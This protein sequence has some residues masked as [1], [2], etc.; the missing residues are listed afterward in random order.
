VSLEDK[1]VPYGPSA[2]IGLQ[3]AISQA[4]GDE[5]LTPVTVIVPSNYVGVATRRLLG[6]GALGPL[7]NSGIGIAAVSFLTV[8]RMAELLGASRLAGAGRRPV[9][10]PV[11][12]ASLRA[13][14]VEN[15]GIFAP[16]AD[17]AATETALVAAY[18]E[19][20]DLPPGALDSLARR[21]NRAAD[22]VRLHRMA[23]VRLE[24]DWYD[25]EDLID[26]ATQVLSTDESATGNGHRRRQST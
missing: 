8:Y 4:K 5:P 22:V 11:I 21:S 23:R 15:P 12:A 1:W 17:H 3:A 26:A 19:L 20:R 6:S 7:C 18:R 10:T 16:V 9:S 13:A 14:L 25:E 24:P 2:A